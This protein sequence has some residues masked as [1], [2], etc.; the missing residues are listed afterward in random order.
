MCDH[1]KRSHDVASSAAVDERVA[2]PIARGAHTAPGDRNPNKYVHHAMSTG[3][4]A[5]NVWIDA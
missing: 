1:G 4:S 2:R 3:A 5:A